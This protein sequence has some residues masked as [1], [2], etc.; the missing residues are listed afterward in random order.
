MA[1]VRRMRRIMLLKEL[2]ILALIVIIILQITALAGNKLYKLMNYTKNEDKEVL[3]KAYLNDILSNMKRHVTALG[4][5]GT[6]V[7]GY[8]GSLI[9]AQYIYNELCKFNITVIKHYYNITIPLDEGSFIVVKLPKGERVLQAFALWPNGIQTCQTPPEGITGR[10]VYVGQGSLKELD[11]VNLRDSIALMEF[12]SFENWITVANLGAKAIIFIEPEETTAEQSFRKTTPASLYLPRLY[13]KHSDGEYLKKFA[14]EGV[15]VTIHVRMRWRKV[16]AANI[17][18]VINGSEYPRDVIVVSTH[19]DSW[20]V[21]PTI[22]PG[23]EDSLGVA[24]LIELAR[25]FSVHRPKRTIWLAAFSGYWQALTG[26]TEW[27]ED[28][29][30]GKE[31]QEEKVRIWLLLDLDLSSDSE[32][33]DVLYTGPYYHFGS[34]TTFAARYGWIQSK[35]L[36][37]LSSTEYALESYFGKKVHDIVRIGIQSGQWGTQPGYRT[38]VDQYFYL[39]EDLPVIQTG[40]LGLTLRTQWSARMRELTP[41]NDYKYIAWKNLRAQLFA[42]FTLISG[43]A[44]E[45]DWRLDYTQIKPRR[46]AGFATWGG[47]SVLG[48]Q[49]IKGKVIEFNYTRSWYT[50]V[51]GAIVRLRYGDPYACPVWMFMAR[52]EI[53]DKDGNFVF[54]GLF[55]YNTWVFDAWKLNETNGQICYSVDQGL[56]GLSRGVVGG[57]SNSLYLTPVAEATVLIPVFKCYNIQVFDLMNPSLMRRAVPV[58]YMNIA[59]SLGIYEYKTKATPIA[60][61]IELDAYYGVGVVHVKPNSLVAITWNPDTNRFIRPCLFLVNASEDMPEGRGIL[62]NKPLLTIHNTAF[63]ASKDLLLSVKARY[64]VMSEHNVRDQVIERFINYTQLRLEKAT[65]YF[66][67]STYGKGYSEALVAWFSIVQAYDATMNRISDISAFQTYLSFLILPFVILFERLVLHGQGAKRIINLIVILTITGALFYTIHPA[68]SLMANSFMALM[69]TSLLL[70]AIAITAVYVRSVFDILERI[71]IRLHGMHI[72]KTEKAAAIMHTLGVSVEHMRKH[73]L[74]TVLILITIV[75][76]VIAQTSLT[77]VSLTLG[78]REASVAGITLPYSGILL[79]RLYAIPPDTHGGV[80][81]FPLLNYL[82]TFTNGQ[83]IISPRVWY[84]PSAIYPEGIVIRIKASN[85]NETTI[86]PMVIL[87][88]SHHE[89]K[90]TFGKYIVKQALGLFEENKYVAVIPRSIAERLGIDIGDKISLLGTGLNLTV[91]AILEENLVK[92]LI[93][94]DGLSLLPVDPIYSPELS[95]GVYQ[96]PLGAQIAPPPIDVSHIIIIPWKTAYEY[97][98]Y[99]ASVALIPTENVTQ[100]NMLN[101]AEA[102]VLSTDITTYVHISKGGVGLFKVY[103]PLF[104]GWEY[105]LSSILP[106]LILSLACTLI[107]IVE[108]RK[109]ELTVYSA[110]GLSPS[111]AAIMFITEFATYAVIGTVIGYILGFALNRLFLTIGILPKEYSMNISSWF[112]LVSLLA[113]LS[114]IIGLSSYPAIV[115]SKLL[116][117]SLERRWKV[118]AKP[119]G[120]LWEIVL[121]FKITSKRESLGVLLYIAEYFSG[122]GAVHRGYV[123]KSVKVFVEHISLV[124]E[125]A[126]TPLE[127]GVSQKVIIAFIQRSAK[128]FTPVLQIKRLSGNRKIWE[129][130]NYLFI[131]AVRKE[132]LLWRSL[133]PKEKEKYIIKA[134]QL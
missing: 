32:G 70:M 82:Y 75:C 78:I 44:N 39:L 83:Y 26:V 77:S 6:R 126:L 121:P 119:R 113:I 79:K 115:A 96:Q 128:E 30:F 103:L 72:F 33:L 98:G 129:A 48:F 81:D 47:T 52:H 108:Q 3:S 105:V 7:T 84:Y 88:L 37:Y 110:C 14:S 8:E 80:L 106:L 123:I 57:I 91:C 95:R 55:P 29:L 28:V 34:T 53:A 104:G 124:M 97:G 62:V 21:V 56:Y 40:V 23:Y 65:K 111:G 42:I 89:L 45:D 100:E 64:K 102:I 63:K 132:L 73:R 10:L 12:N 85:G 134:K 67:N 125:V 76:Y 58:S 130:R 87:G 71:S 22:A 114:S 19:Y 17:V 27:A 5:I 131:D 116:V 99:I 4:S 74:I 94:F 90:L 36:E 68:W 25:Y 122:I 92:S 15:N 117:P 50:P 118:R 51:S 11:G 13:V 133:P 69:G 60:Y 46:F 49:S 127:M 9:A 101:I 31:V 43:F 41:L 1:M 38:G 18:G 112:V 109:R 86:S 16:P 120:D 59:P 107:G 66:E 54:H 2:Y 24:A 93:D 35:V 20:S 61:G